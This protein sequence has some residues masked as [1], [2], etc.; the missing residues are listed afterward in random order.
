VSGKKEEMGRKKVK[1]GRSTWLTSVLK[2]EAADLK[3]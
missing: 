3:Y 1:D 2:M